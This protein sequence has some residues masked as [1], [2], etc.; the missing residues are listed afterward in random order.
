MGQE[1]TIPTTQAAIWRIQQES[2]ALILIL[3]LKGKTSTKI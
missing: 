2:P 1:I 3:E